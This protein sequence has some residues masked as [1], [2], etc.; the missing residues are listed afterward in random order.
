VTGDS[1]TDSDSR[2]NWKRNKWS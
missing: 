1:E 2:W